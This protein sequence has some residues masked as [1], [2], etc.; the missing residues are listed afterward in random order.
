MTAPIIRIAPDF[1]LLKKTRFDSVIDVRSPSEFQDDHMPGAINLPVLDD[2]Q[3]AKIGRL[4]APGIWS[5]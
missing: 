1:A 3:R 2:A 4:I 5:S